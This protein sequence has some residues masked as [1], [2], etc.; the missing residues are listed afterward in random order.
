MFKYMLNKLN[1]IKVRNVAFAI[2]EMF[3]MFI[4]S[5]IS[6]VLLN[7]NQLGRP[8]KATKP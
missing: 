2:N 7:Y 4:L 6:L 8:T 3:F 5:N 1:L